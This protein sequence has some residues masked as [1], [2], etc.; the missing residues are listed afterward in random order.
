MNKLVNVRRSNRGHQKPNAT[1]SK[2]HNWKGGK[3]IS[4]R[5]WKIRV[6]VNRYRLQSRVIMEQLLGRP[7]KRTEIVHH[8]NEDTLD[9]RPKNLELCPNL[10]IHLKEKHALVRWSRKYDSCSVCSTTEHSHSARGM[11]HP[12]YRHW[13]WITDHN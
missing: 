6:G 5:R 13:K 4:D 7:L 1:G 9:D 2:N 8:R 12:C 11:C 3:Y 10:T